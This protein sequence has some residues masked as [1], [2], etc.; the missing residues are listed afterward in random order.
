MCLDLREPSQVAVSDTRHRLDRG[1]VLES[2]GEL[3][4]ADFERAIELD[5]VVDDLLL[6]QRRQNDGADAGLL[7]ETGDL[8]FACRRRGRG[9][10]RRA[11]IE[12]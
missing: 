9:D 5:L 4:G 3:A 10:D 12:A 7:E 2:F 11:Q 6:E 1:E 8:G